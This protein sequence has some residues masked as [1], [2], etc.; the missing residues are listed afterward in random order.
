M[1]GLEI[2]G[3]ETFIEDALCFHGASSSYFAAA[4]PLC[5]PFLL[6]LVSQLLKSLLTTVAARCVSPA[7]T[8]CISLDCLSHLVNM[9]SLFNR[10]TPATTQQ[11]NPFLG[12]TA[13]TQSS[14]LFGNQQQSQQPAQSLFA[15][16]TQN[17]QQPTSSVFG[18]AAQ[19]QQPLNSLFGQSKPAAGLFGN[20][21]NQQQ[22]QQSSLFGTQ[23]A[24]QPQQAQQQPQLGSVL[25]A[26]QNN[27]RIW[28]ESDLQPRTISASL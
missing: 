3:T 19:N 9:A 7:R 14:S 17:Q 18:N 21:T 11:S 1:R 23:N 10:V 2:L 12:G 27:S 22:P 16:S 24:Q 5:F 25:G 8:H 13:Q 26:S 6:N 4:P 28:N 15:A 20:S